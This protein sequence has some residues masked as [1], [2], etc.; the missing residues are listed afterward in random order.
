MGSRDLNYLIKYKI[1]KAIVNFYE[2]HGIITAAPRIKVTSAEIVAR[3]PELAEYENKCAI[4]SEFC[5]NQTKSGQAR[6]NERGNFRRK[7]FAGLEKE[8]E[9]SQKIYLE[10]KNEKS[11][12]IVP[13]F[14]VFIDFDGRKKG[15]LHKI[16]EGITTSLNIG[17]ISQQ[18]YSLGL[19][20]FY[21]I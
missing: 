18:Y 21:K 11:K 2:D 9:L 1:M 7:L 8:A 15:N 20:N 10:I 19:K 17:G 13:D 14:K 6:K 5:G 4:Y 3:N 12:L 16:I